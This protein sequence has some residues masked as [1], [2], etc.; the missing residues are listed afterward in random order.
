MFV[1]ASIMI[2]I[3]VNSILLNY[4]DYNLEKILGDELLLAKYQSKCEEVLILRK[5]LAAAKGAS[6]DVDATSNSQTKLTQDENGAGE[7]LLGKHLPLPPVKPPPSRSRYFGRAGM[8]ME[9][10]RKG[11]GRLFRDNSR[12]QL[13]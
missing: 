5:E 8:M 3:T 2:C 9:L 1:Q 10:A 12:P 4:S 6:V 7:E 13:F 11:N